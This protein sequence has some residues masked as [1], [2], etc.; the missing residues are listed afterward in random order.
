MATGK[1]WP[2]VTALRDWN[3]CPQWKPQSLARAVPTLEPEGV[4]LISVSATFLFL[5]SEICGVL[6]LISHS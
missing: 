6:F 2:G 5:V 3:E 1:Q 4:D